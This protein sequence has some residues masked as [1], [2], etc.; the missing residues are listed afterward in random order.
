MKKMKIDMKKFSIICAGVS[1]LVSLPGCLKDDPLNDFN[2]TAKDIVELPY[3]GLEGFSSDNVVTAGQTDPI[4]LP[5]VV[6]IASVYP[7]SQDVNVTLAIDDALRTQYNAQGGNQYQPLPDST[8]SFTETSGKITSGNRLDTLYVT[9]FPEKVDP[10]SNYMLPIKIADA[11][12]QTISGNFGAI[13]VHMIGNPL[14]GNYDEPTGTRYNYT[15]SV[16]WAGPPAALP[17]GGSVAADYSGSVV[18]ASPVDAHT[19]SM[20][21]GNVPDPVAGGATYIIT[22]SDDYSSITYTFEQNFLDGYSNIQKYIISYTPPT[23][24]QKPAFHLISKY[25]NTTGG[26]GNDR[27]ID[28]TFVH[29]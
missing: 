4:K 24:G 20:R 3:H 7:L 23:G 25:N 26:A 12:G 5:I 10:S 17:P 9:I 15:G 11:S 1:F 18:L 2:S 21:M 16:S 8:Y 19:V 13:Y 27:V 14:A 22:A 29:Q 6:N 28:E